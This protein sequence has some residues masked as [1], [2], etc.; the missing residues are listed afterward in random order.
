MLYFKHNDKS[1]KKYKMKNELNK[2]M[3]IFV[4]NRCTYTIYIEIL[5]DSL[6]KYLRN[7][8]IDKCIADNTEILKIRLYELLN[9]FRA[10]R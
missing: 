8:S 4:M 1:K 3:P 6:R 7:S 2:N 5:F 9:F 10:K